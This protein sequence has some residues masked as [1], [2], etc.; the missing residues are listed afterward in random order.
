MSYKNMLYA[1]IIILYFPVSGYAA[2]I[3]GV[4]TATFNT[5]VGEQQYTYE[6]SVKG[7]ELTGSMK[8]GNGESKIENGK[9]EGDTV[10]FVENL[11]YQGTALRVD[12]TGKIVSNDEI[13]FSRQVGEFATEQL[14]ARRVK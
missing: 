6:F 8:S 9:V 7:K 5:Q 3:S 2:D 1:L 14:T 13:S 11:D 12:Y 4:W 10:T